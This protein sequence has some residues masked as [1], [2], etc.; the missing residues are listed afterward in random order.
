MT[1]IAPGIGAPTN[2]VGQT[3]PAISPFGGYAF[4][5]HPFGLQA[6]QYIQPQQ[7]QQVLQ[8]LL[9][10]VPQ[11]LQQ[12]LHI[13]PQQLQHLHNVQQQQVHQLQQLLQILP[14]QLQQLQQLVQNLP[15]QLHQQPF[16]AAQ[17]L[18][19][20]Q[21][22]NVAAFGAGLPQQAAGPWGFSAAG[23]GVQPLGY[24]QPAGIQPHT[25]GYGAQSSQLM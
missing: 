1:G 12:L 20:I 4:A 25:F 13:V 16:H 21:S 15:Q 24:P 9:Q 7:Q 18:G 22:P 6:Q 10:T 3:F 2:Y 17:P 11:Q 8:Q 23:Q 14:Q 5:T 19:T